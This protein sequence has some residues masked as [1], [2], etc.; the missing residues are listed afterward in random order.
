MIR[1]PR[2]GRTSRSQR[3]E[4]NLIGAAI[5]AALSIGACGPA[6]G[7]VVHPSPTPVAA[8]QTPPEAASPEPSPTPT[9]S[10]VFIIV[11]E[12]RSASQ[13]IT[14]RYTSQLATQYGVATNYRG[15]SHP[16]LPNYLA[17]TSGSTWG[18]T[19]DG[20]HNLPAGGLGAQMT[21]AG[22]E[23][24]A[25]MEGM[26]GNC[27]RNGNGYALKHNPFAYYGSA[28]PAQV[29][30][31]S[32][33]SNDMSAGV[34]RF[35]WITPD[36]CH[37]G[38]DCST[39]TADSWLEQT[40]PT[41]L[42]SSAWRDNGVLFI[43]WDEGEDSANSVLTLVIQPDQLNHSSSQAYNHYS[44]LAAIEDRLGVARL[45]AA[46]PA[47]PMTDLLATRPSD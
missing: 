14:G 42:A 28:C 4:R 1:P 26:G 5:V 18:I 45:G 35:V 20:F 19:D 3:F 12:N 25:Y 15:V 21:A 13:A 33:F 30:P 36:M 6:S 7:K 24:R 27:F 16:S 9:P 23:W 11:M 17:M 47:E 22:I 44:L 10:H 31:F 40:V 8:V 29:V 39:A 34:P 43:T 46:A 41:I 38:H 2:S 37:D 32:Q